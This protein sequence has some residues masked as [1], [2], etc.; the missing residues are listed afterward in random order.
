[1]AEGEL[2]LLRSQLKKLEEEVAELSKEM[3]VLIAQWNEEKEVLERVS[4]TKKELEVQSPCY[5]LVNAHAVT[6]TL[7]MV[8]DCTPRARQVTA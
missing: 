5:T 4:R 7:H 3:D 1:M 6:H 8:T 2:G